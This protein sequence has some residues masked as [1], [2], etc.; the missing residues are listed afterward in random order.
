MTI[1]VCFFKIVTKV[2]FMITCKELVTISY[3]ICTKKCIYRLQSFEKILGNN[4]NPKD[5][6]INL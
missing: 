4:D 2:W 5:K 3:A 6:T 1:S